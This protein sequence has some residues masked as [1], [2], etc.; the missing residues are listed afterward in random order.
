MML[1]NSRNSGRAVGLISELPDAN[2]MSEWN[3]LTPVAGSNSNSGYF[4]ASSSNRRVVSFERGL[5][6]F[7]ALFR[8][9]T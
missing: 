4:F 7:L 5:G 1:A 6:P 8:R 3:L 9:L 2:R